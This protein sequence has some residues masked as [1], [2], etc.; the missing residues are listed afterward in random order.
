[1][2]HTKKECDKYCKPWYKKYVFKKAKEVKVIKPDKIY[3][4][5]HFF[6]HSTK[7]PIFPDDN[8]YYLI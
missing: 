8:Y 7:K 3:N 5:P 4:L 1:M 2:D 6:D